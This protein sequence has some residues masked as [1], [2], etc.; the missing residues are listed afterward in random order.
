MAQQKQ[1]KGETRLEYFQRL[2]LNAITGWPLKS[3]SNTAVRMSSIS[4]V[5]TRPFGFSSKHD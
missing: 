5:A 4:R 1:K 2:G 3:C